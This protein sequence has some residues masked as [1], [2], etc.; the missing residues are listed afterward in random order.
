MGFFTKDYIAG[1]S[2]HIIPD[3]TF[4]HFGI[5]TSSMHIAWTRYVCGKLKSDY[6]YSKELVYNNFP[7]P[8]PT[9]KQITAIEKTA[10]E[11]LYARAQFPND[12]LAKLYDPAAMPT[13]LSKAHQKLDKAVEAAYG[14]P[15][16]DDSRRVAHLF[17]LYQKLCSNLKFSYQS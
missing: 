17:E 2:C 6:R 15:F 13:A 3:G 9:E 4:Y 8:N 7:W 10:L 5:L 11:V 12:S 16:D 1:N 14:H